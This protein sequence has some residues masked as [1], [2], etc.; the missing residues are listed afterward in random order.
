MKSASKSENSLPETEEQ[1]INTNQD[2]KI[3]RLQEEVRK[4]NESAV[5][6]QELTIKQNITQNQGTTLVSF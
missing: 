1:K 5:T 3:H 2:L 6:N 4:N